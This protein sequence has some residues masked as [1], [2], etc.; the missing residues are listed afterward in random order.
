[1]TQQA[2]HLSH[3]QIDHFTEQGRRDTQEDRMFIHVFV[4]ESE[5]ELGHFIAI[6]DGH[7]GSKTADAILEMLPYSMPTFAHALQSGQFK[8]SEIL[9]TLCETL[10]SSTEHFTAGTTLTCAFIEVA[11]MRLNIAQ[12]GD[13][14]LL[15]VRDG[16]IVTATTSHNA[17]MNKIDRFT[18]IARGARWDGGY[19]CNGSAGIQCTRTLGDKNI[20]QIIR[21]PEISAHPIF[22]GD[23]IVLATD[24]VLSTNNAKAYKAEAADI[25]QLL[26]RR[27]DLPAEQLTYYGMGIRG[28]SD[29]ATT[30]LVRIS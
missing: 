16:K 19:L 9:G 28:S 10:R 13:S 23:V 27:P 24:G 4:D 25:A 20:P 1:M 22:P 30:I 2:L 14:A 29:N 3:F 11:Q 8:F 17:R 6:L 18:M 26:K 7:G 12:L 15:L 21:T 5:N